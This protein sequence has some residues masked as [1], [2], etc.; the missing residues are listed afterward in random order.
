MFFFFSLLFLFSVSYQYLCLLSVFAATA[1]E[2][3]EQADEMHVDKVKKQKQRKSHE[4]RK[5]LP[6]T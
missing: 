2:G 5:E 3:V 4:T 1:D 6:S